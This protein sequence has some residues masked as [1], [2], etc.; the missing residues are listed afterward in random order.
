MSYCYNHSVEQFTLQPSKHNCALG[1]DDSSVVC[2]VQCLQTDQTSTLSNKCK[3]YQFPKIAP[4][5]TNQSDPSKCPTVDWQTY[6]DAANSYDSNGT[7]YYCADAD[8]SQDSTKP[9]SNIKTTTVVAPC[10][11]RWS[12]L[13]NVNEGLTYASDWNSSC[14]NMAQTMV[15][16]GKYKSV[17]CFNMSQTDFGIEWGEYAQAW[18]SVGYDVSAKDYANGL[19]CQ[20]NPK[21]AT[22]ECDTLGNLCDTDMFTEKMTDDKDS[23]IIQESTNTVME[24]LQDVMEAIS[25]AME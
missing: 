13:Y 7:L 21:N 14:N 18:P 12:Q 8:L 9:C 20:L 22:T 15:K 3:K 24:T 11:K 1:F 19:A 6:A 16:D 23:T 2:D 25:E 4:D 5:T 17:A 10:N